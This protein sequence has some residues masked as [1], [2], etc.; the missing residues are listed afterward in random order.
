MVSSKQRHLTLTWLDCRRRLSNL[1]Y[2]SLKKSQA[3]FADNWCWCRAWT[4]DA[5]YSPT[6]EQVTLLTPAPFDATASSAK[7]QLRVGDGDATEAALAFPGRLCLGLCRGESGGGWAA[8]RWGQ[9]SLHWPRPAAVVNVAIMYEAGRF[10]SDQL[11]RCLLAP[12]NTD[13]VYSSRGAGGRRG[14]VRY[15][16]GGRP[17]SGV[18]NGAPGSRVNM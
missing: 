5:S 3:S 9:L 11:R 7:D 12:T 17:A 6:H 13:V 10:A 1:L 14:L 15:D 8:D 16:P 18:S 2:H 4:S